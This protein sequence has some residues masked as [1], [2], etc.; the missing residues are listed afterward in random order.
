MCVHGTQIKPNPPLTKSRGNVELGTERVAGAAAGKANQNLLSI[1]SRSICKSCTDR[2]ISRLRAS[3]TFPLPTPALFF[4]F[5]SQLCPVMPVR[6]LEEGRDSVF[7]HP[8]TQPLLSEL[9]TSLFFHRPPWGPPK[10]FEPSPSLRAL[11]SSFSLIC[12]GASC[13][14]GK[15]VSKFSWKAAQPSFSQSR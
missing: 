12:P 15:E 8:D 10:A 5:T 13:L 6:A 14:P 1:S 2:G 11:L 4:P 9:L 3:R 7:K